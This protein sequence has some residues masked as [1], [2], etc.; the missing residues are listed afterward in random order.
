MIWNFLTISWKKVWNLEYF[1]YE[2]EAHFSKP[3]EPC[4]DERL[5][6]F[7]KIL[8]VFPNMFPNVRTQGLMNR[9]RK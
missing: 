9:L 5:A 4:T 3:S 2:S 8:N 6:Y 1:T 7:W